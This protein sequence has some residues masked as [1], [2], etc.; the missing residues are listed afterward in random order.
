MKKLLSVAAFILLLASHASA[1]FTKLLEFSGSPLANGLTPTVGS[2]RG[3]FMD[4]NGDGVPD[5]IISDK[6]TPKLD[7]V[8]G[9]NHSERWEYPLTGILPSAVQKLRF[10][11]FYE[12]DGDQSFKEVV[13]GERSGN[14]IIAILIAIFDD[15]P[16]ARFGEE[17]RLM[18][19]GDYLGNGKMQIL[20][21]D[22]APANPRIELWGYE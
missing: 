11:G 8:S 13:M 16:V 4:A 3:D 15:S 2:S 5:L 10:F 6:S 21:T 1:Q 7:V 22:P 18:G 17:Y 9:A 20:I 19:I 14:K 12:L